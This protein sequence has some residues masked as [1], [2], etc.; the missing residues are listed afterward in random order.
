M[1]FDSKLEQR[2]FVMLRDRGYH[3]TPQVEVNTRSIDLV[4]TGA[5]GRL[6]VECDGDYWHSG[7]DAQLADLDRELELR[8]A[9]W[10]F[11]RVRESE[12]YLDP[13]QGLASLW[14]ALEK[15]GI[16][17][18]DLSPPAAPQIDEDEQIWD[19]FALAELEGLDGLDGADASE[20]DAVDRSTVK[21][22]TRM[23]LAI[24]GDPTSASPAPQRIADGTLQPRWRSA[25]GRD[26]N[27]SA[28]ATGD[29]SIPML[30]TRGTR[31][32]LIGPTDRHLGPNVVAR[33]AR[34][35]HPLAPRGSAR[36]ARRPGA[37]VV[38][39]RRHRRTSHATTLSRVAEP[40]VN[41]ISVFAIDLGPPR[42]IGWWRAGHD[43]A[44]G[45]G[46][47][48]DELVVLSRSRPQQWIRRCIGLR[49]RSSPRAR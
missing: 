32:T 11:W 23:A 8:R 4:V 5:R 9:G 46:S 40:S 42:N 34:H 7:R 27:A 25:T 22:P 16:R 24:D 12:F 36:P 13:E 29:A 45:G 38:A 10:Q 49:H 39:S 6:A 28:S 35:R 48:L 44:Y 26:P 17:P 14:P 43:R 31:R 21:P 3:V 15:R 1:P 33:R 30:S 37:H 18:G 2:V 20:L 47:G 19:P 41:R